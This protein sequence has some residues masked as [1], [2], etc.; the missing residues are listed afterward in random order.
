MIPAITSEAMPTRIVTIQPI[1][2][3]PGWN[4]RPSAPTRAPTM[5]SHT[6]CMRSP[7][8]VRERKRRSGAV[9]CARLDGGERHELPPQLLDLVP[10]LGGVLEAQLLRRGEHLL[11]ELDHELLELLARHPL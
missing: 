5:I 4:N 2:S 3:E 7:F 6:Q 9:G 8:G 1:G 11:L 10:Q